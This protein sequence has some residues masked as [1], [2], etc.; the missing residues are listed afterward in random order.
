MS[1][2]FIVSFYLKHNHFFYGLSQICVSIS[3]FVLL[4]RKKSRSRL[5]K[6]RKE[7]ETE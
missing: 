6:V 5:K 1:V 4:K 3:Y 7:N 2:E